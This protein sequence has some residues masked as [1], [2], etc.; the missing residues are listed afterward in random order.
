MDAARLPAE[1]QLS[2]LLVLDSDGQPYAIVPSSQL[3]GQL[4]PSCLHEGPMIAASINDRHLGEVAAQLAGIIVAQWLP[5]P[6]VRPSSVGLDAGVLQ[7][8][9]LMGRTHSP[10][11]AVVERDGD[12]TDL[13]GAVTAARLM[14]RLIGG[15]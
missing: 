6:R 13:V 1:Y 12:H 9:A 14:E 5:C 2:A 4:L 10:V 11:V 3:F 7:I 8:A 15:P